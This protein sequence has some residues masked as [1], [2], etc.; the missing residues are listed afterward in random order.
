MYNNQKIFEITSDFSTY[1]LISVIENNQL[2]LICKEINPPSQYEN[3]LLISLN[4]LRDLNPIFNKCINIQEAQKIINNEI[5]NGKYSVIDHKSHMDLKLFMS[6]SNSQIIPQ[7]SPEDY[8]PMGI[9]YNYS[10]RKKNREILTLVLGEK[11]YNNNFDFDEP[12]TININNN[13]YHDTNSLLDTDYKS[14]SDSPNNFEINNIDNINENSSFNK[15]YNLSPNKDVYY[16]DII[17][18]YELENQNLK[19][20]IIQM[21]KQ[22]KSFL[23][24]NTNFYGNND[25]NYQKNIDDKQKINNNLLI[26]N[27]NLKKSLEEFRKTTLIVND[28]EIIMARG[29]II[30][31]NEEIGFL[32]KKIAK[33]SENIRIDLI[34]KASVDGDKA[35]DFHRKCDSA[36]S[37]LV[38]IETDNNLR[39]GGFTSCDW[40][41]NAEDKYDDN[42][43]VFSLDKGRIYDIKPGEKAIGCY[44]DFGPV[45]LGCQIKINDDAFTNNGSTYRKNETYQTEEDFELNGGNEFFKIKD[46]E[47]YSIELD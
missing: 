31:N 25:N 21:D 4:E 32:C 7:I 44:P 42:A 23:S 3:T 20:Q 35:E 30:Q 1:H 15:D 38:L 40:S 2:R 22:I 34:Y 36:K 27:N 24:N 11:R 9:H 6:G 12:I 29:E 47:V 14:R 39:F 19:N 43:F 26:E 10:E 17:N 5:E 18:K 33:N 46:I 8:L 37:T 28:S 16:Q 41:G 13:H 45:F